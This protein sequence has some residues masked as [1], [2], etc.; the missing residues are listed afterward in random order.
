ME[1]SGHDPAVCPS[2]LEPLA[3]RN[4]SLITGINR[5]YFQGALDRNPSLQARTAAFQLGFDAADHAID[6]PTKAPW[7]EGKLVALYPG[8]FLPLSAP[9][10]RIILQA[11]KTLDVQGKLRTEACMVYIGTGHAEQPIQSIAEELGIAHR[12]IELPD[13]HPLLGSAA[14]VALRARVHGHRLTGT[15]LF[16]L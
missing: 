15:P 10:H 16:R 3:L 11:F 8:A 12:V 1:P 2:M 7:P 5:P 4:A 9:F 6:H 13:S 14:V